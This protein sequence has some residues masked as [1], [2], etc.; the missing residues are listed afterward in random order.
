MNKSYYHFFCVRDSVKSIEKVVTSLLDQ[1]IPPKE[2]I[3]VDDNSTD[4]TGDIL[5]S[6]QKEFPNIITLYKTQNETRDYSRIPTLWNMCLKRNYDF[7][8]IGAG[9]VSYRKNYA[10]KLLEEF[11]NDPKLVICSGDVYPFIGIA[12]HGGGRFV[13]QSFFFKYYEKYPEIM[14]YESEILH[15]ALIKE[16]KIKNFNDVE[17]EHHEEL[18]GKHNFEEFGRGMKALGYHP[19]YAI[20]RCFLEFVKNN[21]V[22]RKGSLNMF[23]KY[24][25][26]KPQTQ[27]YF[28]RFPDDIRKEIRDYQRKKIRQFLKNPSKILKKISH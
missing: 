14:G 8:M 11:N 26:Y 28:S 16:Y 12:P 24:V 13:R 18:G 7:H 9:D 10:E 1:T 21:N 19:A 27:G 22:G 23:W 15:R 25:T 6:F 3:V 4:G 20:G 5:E 17:M 2:I